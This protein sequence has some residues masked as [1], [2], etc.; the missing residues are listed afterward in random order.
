MAF[1]MQP[2]LADLR[3]EVVMSRR[4]VRPPGLSEQEMG[5]SVLLVRSFRAAACQAAERRAEDDK[6]PNG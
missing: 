2:D 1:K 5:L 3:K 6:G 4:A